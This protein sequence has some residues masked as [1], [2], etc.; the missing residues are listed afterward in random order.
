KNVYAWSKDGNINLLLS[1]GLLKIIGKG[2]LPVLKTINDNEVLCLWE[3]N[4]KIFKKKENILRS[5]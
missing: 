5:C 2:S 4:K 3:N 1:D